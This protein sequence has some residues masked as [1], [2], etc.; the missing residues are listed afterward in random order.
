MILN[1]NFKFRLR[2][3]REQKTLF[4]QF[5]GARRWVYN[6]GL[7]QRKASWEKENHA[8]IL[9]DQN[10]E[11]T[12]LKGQE[13]TSWLKEVHSQV[14]QQAL[15]DLNQAFLS[16]FR[17]VKQK[18]TPGYPRFRCKGERDF[19]RYPQGV[20]I[21]RDRAYLPKIGWVRFRAIFIISSELATGVARTKAVQEYRTPNL[22]LRRRHLAVSSDMECCT[23]VQLWLR[24]RLCPLSTQKRPASMTKL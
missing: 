15:H 1:R 12:Q 22:N 3:N 11:L 24:A 20:K 7:A 10:K 6:R 2:P 8:I 16:F 13:E 14:L 17:R 21:E 23:P 19:F 18:E 4:T 9:F 5:A